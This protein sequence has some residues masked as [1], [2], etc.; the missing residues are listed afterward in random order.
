M[1]DTCTQI[2]SLNL[3]NFNTS[4][5]KSMYQ[6]FYDCNQLKSLDISIVTT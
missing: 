5:V 6:M 4:L 3:S 1:F 2:E